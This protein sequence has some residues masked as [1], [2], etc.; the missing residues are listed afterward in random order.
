MALCYPT[1]EAKLQV[2]NLDSERHFLVAEIGAAR[3]R[4]SASEPQ[5]HA[6]LHCRERKWRKVME[7]FKLLFLFVEDCLCPTRL[8]VCLSS[9][10]HESF[11]SVA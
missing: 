6:R 7:R 8:S 10:S 2:H 4:A 1:D 11:V 9:L 3:D 5:D